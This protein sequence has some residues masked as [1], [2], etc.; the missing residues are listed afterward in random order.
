MP[1]LQK[2]ACPTGCNT[3]ILP[4][5]NFDLCLPEVNP[6]EIEELYVAT[7]DAAP[8][9]DVTDPAEWAD[10]LDQSATTAGKI[11]RFLVV[12]DKPAASDQKKTISKNREILTDA[13]HVINFEID[14][15]ND[16]NYDAVRQIQ[17]QQ[18]WRIWWKTRGNKNYGGNEGILVNMAIRDV[19]GR[20][21]EI[22]KFVGTA[23]WKSKFDAPRVT[24]PI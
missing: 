7:P 11:R 12:G 16:V 21:D 22:E 18:S 20:G 8:F 4:P 3:Q 9:G 10:R 14:E 5:V 24:S 15:T 2:P 23:T 17:C 19:L 13:T 6:S 1:L